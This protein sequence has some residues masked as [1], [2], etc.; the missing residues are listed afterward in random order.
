MIGDR[1]CPAPPSERGPHVRA[2][3]PESAPARFGATR[4]PFAATTR[5]AAGSPASMHRAAEGTTDV[6]LLVVRSRSRSGGARG[7]GGAWLPRLA[8]RGGRLR[9]SCK[10]RLASTRSSTR[11]QREHALSSSVPRRML[12]ERE[13]RDA[14]VVRAGDICFLKHWFKNGQGRSEW[15]GDQVG[16]L[17]QFRQKDLALSL[18]K[19]R[20]R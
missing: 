12:S 15:V 18:A 10:K 4:D 8:R 3:G 1:S 9:L 11:G 14:R 17:S 2:K 7:A 6:T 16:V 5:A 19:R 13:T 20:L